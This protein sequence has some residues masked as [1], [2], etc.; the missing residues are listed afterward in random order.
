MAAKQGLS[1]QLSQASEDA[2]RAVLQRTSL[3]SSLWFSNLNTTCTI[4]SAPPRT[5]EVLSLLSTKS[6]WLFKRNEQHVWQSRWCCVVP[7]TFLYYF[8]ANVLPGQAQ[9]PVPTASQQETWN[10]AIKEGYGGR[11]KHHAPRSTFLFSS[12]YNNSNSNPEDPASTHD[13]VSDLP[14]SSLGG[15]GIPGIG[16]GITSN[17]PNNG[18]SSFTSLQPAGIIDLECYTSIHRSSQNQLVMELAGDDAV[19][20]DLRSFYFCANDQDE[21]EDWS[22]TLLGQRHSALLDE[23]DA[24]KQVC[25][26][27]AQQLQFLHQEMDMAAKQ[28]EDTQEELY[29]VRSQMEEQRRT[30]WKIIEQALQ[31][32][33]VPHLADTNNTDKVNNSKKALDS[34]KSAYQADLNTIKTQDMGLVAAVQLLSNYSRGLDENCAELAKQ[35]DSVKEKLHEANHEDHERALTLEKEIES[36]KRTMQDEKDKW[37]RDEELSQQRFNQ[38]HKELEDVQKELSSTR[39]EV[40]MYQSSTRNKLSELQNHKKILKK[41]VIDLRQKLEDAHSEISLIQHKHKTNQMEVEQERKKTELLE[42]YVDKMESQ[43][44]VQHNMMEMMSASGVGSIHGDRSVIHNYDNY[45]NNNQNQYSPTGRKIVVVNTPNSVHAEDDIDGKGRLQRLKARSG[46][47]GMQ[48][49]VVGTIQSKETDELANLP[50]LLRRSVIDNDVDNKSHMSELTEDRTQKHFDTVF[51]REFGQNYAENHHTTT[52]PGASPR[53]VIR[54]ASPRSNMTRNQGNG[55]PSYIIGVGGGASNGNGG[56]GGVASHQQLMQQFNS[57]I[58]GDNT[59]ILDTISSSNRV[60]T[61]QLPQPITTPTGRPGTGLRSEIPRSDKSFRRDAAD[62]M[63]L[64]SNGSTTQ[65]LSVAHRARLEADRQSTPVKIRVNDPNM[66]SRTSSSANMS[67]NCP[68]SSG[69]SVSSRDEGSG[70]FSSFGKRLEEAIDKSV[71]G[72]D[73]DDDN[74][75]SLGG[76]SHAD[77]A[78]FNSCH[79][80]LCNTASISNGKERGKDPER[81]IDCARN[82]NVTRHALLEEKKSQERTE[83]TN[84]SLHERQQ[85]QRAKQMKFLKENGMIKQETDLRGGAGAA[86]PTY[87]T[88]SVTSANLSFREGSI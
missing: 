20:P 87:D 34:T 85:I 60:N 7:H 14:Q 49:G 58:N 82:V 6:G 47:S 45:D 18:D 40:T 83:K 79:G 53:G 56:G 57:S 84:L 69:N 75:S 36:M 9:P 38:K 15:I 62:S 50:Q 55:P 21:T 88:S 51:L 64:G 8:D 41:E 80:S 32:T 27:F 29:R 86:S 39:M 72:V 61:A 33:A 17:N 23:S 66:P 76:S 31:Q 73:M 3:T 42:R 43:V 16:G 52:P 2:K 59:R 24:Y 26:G 4:K 65:R 1:A 63:S 11:S 10:M 35:N 19:N 28:Q 25:D 13:T 22:Q 68:P 54:L 44:K 71:F 67:N 46:S 77:S 74:R 48:S 30:S 5:P 78:K 37:K 81:S 12:N 70:F